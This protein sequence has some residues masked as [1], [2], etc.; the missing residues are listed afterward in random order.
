MSISREQVKEAL[1]EFP[2][3]IIS[4]ERLVRRRVQTF[5]RVILATVFFWLGSLISIGAT[6]LAKVASKDQPVK[7]RSSSRHYKRHKHSYEANSS[8]IGTASWY[9]HKFHNRKTA[10]GKRYNQDAMMAAHRTLPFGTMVRVTNLSNDKSC[11]VEIADRGPFVKH[12]IID[13]SRRAASEL[14]FSGTAQVRLEVLSPSYLA[15]NRSDFH[16]IISRSD[17]LK[18]PEMAVK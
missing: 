15:F 1:K 14:G 9:G 7:T 12:R 8:M 17:V 3:E 5:V 10:S 16:S 13:L 11:I 2:K 18:T 4:A 6:A